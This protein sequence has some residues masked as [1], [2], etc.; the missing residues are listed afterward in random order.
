MAKHKDMRRK[1]LE[2]GKIHIIR[3]LDG[4]NIAAYENFGTWHYEIN[5]VSF[6]LSQFE[7]ALTLLSQDFTE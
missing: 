7:Q 2:T 5:G 3:F 6:K 1:A 4:A